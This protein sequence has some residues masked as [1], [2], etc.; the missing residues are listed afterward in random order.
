[1]KQKHP[2]ETSAAV[3]V[4]V[5]DA[6]VAHELGDCSKMQI[7]R[8]SN[9]PD[10]GFPTL[11]KVRRANFRWR[12]EVEAFKKRLTAQALAARHTQQQKRAARENA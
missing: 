5:P 2:P 12:S 1:M 10:V 11:V 4:L 9:D 7:W 6:Q 8:L 3:D